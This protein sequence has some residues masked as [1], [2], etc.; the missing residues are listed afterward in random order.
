[1]GVGIRNDLLEEIVAQLEILAASGGTGVTKEYVDE[2]LALKAPLASPGLTG[3]P[4][5]PTPAVGAGTTQIVNAAFV[6]AEFA[7]RQ[8]APMTLANLFAHDMTGLSAGIECRVSN[9]DYQLFV[10]NG[11]VWKPSSGRLTIAHEQGLMASPIATITGSTG[12]Q[13]TLPGGN[14]QIPANLI[15]E[16]YRVE[17]ESQVIRTGA[18]ATANANVRIGTAGTTADSRMG[19]RSLAATTLTSLRS[20]DFAAFSTSTT[21]AVATVGQQINSGA[22]T[23]ADITTNINTAAL[24]YVSFDISASNVADTFD[25]IGYRV[26]LIME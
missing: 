11:T 14:V 16:D 1:M 15:K 26:T 13:F 6:Q 5:T 4:T 17:V 7:A 2:G 23:M 25:L 21:A 18:T 3:T 10:W 12:A 8:L 22:T 9:Y 24:M 20:F 19:A